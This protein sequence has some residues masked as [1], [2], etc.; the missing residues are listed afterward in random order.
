MTGLDT[1]VHP[2][3]VGRMEKPMSLTQISRRDGYTAY[4]QSPRQPVAVVSLPFRRTR[5]GA[6][7]W[8][9]RLYALDGLDV[10]DDGR[11]MIHAQRVRRPRGTSGWVFTGTHRYFTRNAYEL[12]DVRFVEVVG[13]GATPE[14]EVDPITTMTPEE[15]DEKLFPLWAERWTL[16]SYLHHARR[17]VADYVWPTTRDRK[18][19]PVR[20]WN[21]KAAAEQVAEYEAKLEENAAARK[22]F[23]DEFA[24]RPW[25]R[26]VLCG[27]NNGHLHY[28]GCSSLRITTELLLVAQA[29]GL[30]S[31]EVVGKFGE[32]ACTKCFPG[33]PVAPKSKPLPEGYCSASGSYDVEGVN[34]SLRL[35]RP[36]GRCK[37]CGQGASVTSTGKL[38]RHKET[39]S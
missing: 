15:I 13:G 24:R 4:R 2:V 38:R 37:V 39:A 9:R 11:T 34:G 10:F 28:H 31:A 22:P 12:R 35:W 7:V 32:T 17:T 30:D 18:R 33:A 29:S 8:T 3:Y 16:G 14:P 5:N 1:A 20:E 23:E 27:A 25:V 6:S 26:Y 21:A 36:W 19:M